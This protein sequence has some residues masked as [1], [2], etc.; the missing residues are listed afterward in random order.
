LR[1][2]KRRQAI[3][4]G[5]RGDEAGARALLPDADPQVRAAALGAL[6]RLG[7]ATGDDV[8]AGLAD[9]APVVRVRACEAA[10]GVASADLR[11]ALHDPD[12]A[13]VEAAAW[14]LGERGPGGAEAAVAEAAVAEAAVAEVVDELARVA[15]GHDE[16][17]C[18]EAA[19]A[20]LGAIG[21]RRGLAAVLAATRDRPAIRRRAVIALA[22][23]EGPEVD[24]ALERARLDRDWQVRQA[25]EELGRG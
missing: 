15:G 8:A 4:A 25:A 5:H 12:P 19:V 18:R 14:A 6:A 17:L 3:L 21:D 1:P 2:V 23:F 24:G 13:V 9:P 7:V 20:A 16:P 11:P 10:V 22:A